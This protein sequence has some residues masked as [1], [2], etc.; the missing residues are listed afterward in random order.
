LSG[1]LAEIV[2]A[3]RPESL[4]QGFCEAVGA[5]TDSA[6]R[7]FITEQQADELI[8]HLAA[9]MIQAQFEETFRNWGLAAYRDRSAH[10]S[11]GG[12]NFRRTFV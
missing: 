4:A 6:H 2:A 5:V 1:L 10:R 12:F 3:E 9:L 8:T 11:T 7:G